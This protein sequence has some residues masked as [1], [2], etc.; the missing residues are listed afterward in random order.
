MVLAASRTWLPAFAKASAWAQADAGGPP[1][2]AARAVPPHSARMEARQSAV[3]AL[4]ASGTPSSHVP[5]AAVAFPCSAP[6]SPWSTRSVPPAII[7]WRWCSS[8]LCSICS[9]SS[10]HGS[11]SVSATAAF[12]PAWCTTAARS[13][14]P[15]ARPAGRPWPAPSPT[16]ASQ[17]GATYAKPIAAPAT[18]RGTAPAAGAPAAAGAAEDTSEDAPAAAS[19]PPSLPRAV[20]GRRRRRVL[21]LLLW[22]VG[23]EDRWV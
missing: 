18:T 21:R 9:A 2:A 5:G 7:R 23:E 1:R 20:F 19:P 13:P 14:S 4:S 10:V 8:K 6:T 15:P 22:G 11:H 12:G 3:R 16:C 17:Q